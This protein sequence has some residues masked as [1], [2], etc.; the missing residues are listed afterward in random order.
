MPTITIEV[1]VALPASRIQGT[2][3]DAGG[4]SPFLTEPTRSG[5]EARV[6]I[7]DRKAGTCAVTVELRTERTDHDVVRT[8][9]QR[10]VAALAQ[11]ALA[12]D[13]AEESGRAWH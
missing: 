13:S 12:A 11:R 8:E 2:L 6:S 1:P 10:A 5:P 3:D 9:L 7:A 4:L